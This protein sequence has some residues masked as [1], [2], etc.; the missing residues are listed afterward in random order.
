MQIV[1]HMLDVMVIVSSLNCGRS[2]VAAVATVK[3]GLKLCWI[4]LLLM[5]LMLLVVC[6]LGESVALDCLNCWCCCR[7]L[8]SFASSC[9]LVAKF[10]PFFRESHAP[11]SFQAWVV[12]RSTVLTYVH[13]HHS[14]CVCVKY[15]PLLLLHPYS[16]FPNKFEFELHC[17]N[18]F[19]LINISVVP[20]RA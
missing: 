5:L 7:S 19:E 14:M 8:Q 18:F 13:V 2:D 20:N 1:I 11:L 9:D 17:S 6:W 4:Q 3:S 15:P 16:N 10:G 12:T